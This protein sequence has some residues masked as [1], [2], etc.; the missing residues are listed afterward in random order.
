MAST[1]GRQIARRVSSTYESEVHDGQDGGAYYYSGDLAN[2][3]GGSFYDDEESLSN[4]TK[5]KKN[6]F[7]STFKKCT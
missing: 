1:D 5:D 4:A 6:T 7:R 3:N 2:D